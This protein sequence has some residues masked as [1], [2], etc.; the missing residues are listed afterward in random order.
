M[1]LFGADWVLGEDG[2]RFRHAARVLLFDPEHRL[3]LAR[4]HDLDDPERHWWFTIGGGIE[5]GEDPKEAA[6]RELFEETGIII[7]VEDL[8]GPVLTRTAL[9]D[10]AAETVR[11]HE[12]FYRALLTQPRQFD[13]SGWTATERHWMVS[14]KW[15]PLPDLANLN[16]QI[17]PE[18]LV[19]VAERVSSGWD[20]EVQHM[21]NMD[22]AG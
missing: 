12:V 11:Q 6:M 9:F 10:F 13:T 16:E 20:G 5:A 17:Y 19:A 8:Q 18:G 21:G 22:D 4:G 15:W 2:V 1:S 3:L 7:G 14:L